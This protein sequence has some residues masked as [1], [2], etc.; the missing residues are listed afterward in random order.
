MSCY[1]SELGAF[2]HNEKCAGTSI[3]Q[4]LRQYGWKQYGYIPHIC[5][6]NESDLA[7]NKWT[8]VF[9]RHPW[10]RFVSLYKHFK[11]SNDY[12]YRHLN[13][14]EFIYKVTLIDN[15]TQ[16]RFIRDT[17]LVDFV[18]QFE[19]LEE[20]WKEISSW[21]GI[22]KRLPR[23]NCHGGYDYREYYT[24]SSFKRVEYAESILIDR[25]GY[26]F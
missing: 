24:D 17:S 4:L 23:C 19:K 26:E 12:R 13:F 1:T 5:P 14:G 21:F 20:D 2:F 11:R 16:S 22:S 8:F 6:S 9:V 10:E 25:F 3:G 18:G 15:R 7:R